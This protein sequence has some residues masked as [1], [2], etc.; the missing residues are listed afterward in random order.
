MARRVGKFAVGSLALLDFYG[1]TLDHEVQGRTVE[2][3]VKLVSKQPQIVRSPSAVIFQAND[4]TASG[5]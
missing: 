2:I 1:K 4:S 3:G 5:L